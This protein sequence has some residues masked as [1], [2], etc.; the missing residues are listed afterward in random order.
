[1]SAV[2]QEIIML[3]RVVAAVHN[4]QMYTFNGAQGVHQQ[5]G[6]LVF[7]FS[8]EFDVDRFWGD[9]NGSFVCEE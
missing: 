9:A 2:K 3:P 8:D 6:K 1:M 7:Q 4:G 5:T